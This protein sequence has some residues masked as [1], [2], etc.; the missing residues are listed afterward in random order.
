MKRYD[1]YDACWIMG[2]NPDRA[3]LIEENPVW[4]FLPISFFEIQQ[5]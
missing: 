5:V 3:K 2:N 1:L 4:S